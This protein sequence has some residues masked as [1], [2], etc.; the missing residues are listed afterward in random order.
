MIY[1]TE[2]FFDEI[3]WVARF[4]QGGPDVAAQA[5][6]PEL[7]LERLGVRLRMEIQHYGSVHKIPKFL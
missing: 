4:V 6:S 1:K 3:A 2:V 7:A 5:S